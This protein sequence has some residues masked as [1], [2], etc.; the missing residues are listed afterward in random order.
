V[1]SESCPSDDVLA[2]FVLG[3]LPEEVLDSI[4][5]HQERCARCEFRACQLDEQIDPVIETIRRTISR[6]RDSDQGFVGDDPA[7]EPIVRTDRVGPEGRCISFGGPD[8]ASAPL[9]GEL[10][11]RERGLVAHERTN[12]P[13]PILPDYEIGESLL[14]RGSMG[15]VYKARHRKLN[16]VVALKM[17]A[18]SSSRAS[19]LFQIEAKAVA[20][21]QHPNIVQIFDIGNSDGQPFLALE[22]VEGGSLDQ[23]IAGHP[24]PPKFA[25][26]MVRTLARAA[27]YAH[28]QGIVHCDL[29]PSNILVTPDGIPKIADFGVA[30]W[31]ESENQW[32]HDG[33]IVGTPC[34]MAPEQASGQVKSVG[35][36]T[37]VYSL[38]VILYEMLTGRPPH[39]ASTS[40]EILTLV[41]EQE[42]VS[43]RQIQPRLPRDLETI[44]LKSLRKEPAKRYTDARSLAEDLDRFLTG[45]PI[46]ARRISRVERSYLWARRHRRSLSLVT[47]ITAFWLVILG[48]ALFRHSTLVPWY[49]A[50]PQFESRAAP[51]LRPVTPNKTIVQADGS[52]RLGAASAAIHG[53]SL[54]FEAPFGNLGYWH[55][56]NDRAVWTFQVYRPATFTL[57]VD[58]ACIDADAGNRYEVAIG[59]TLFRGVVTGTGSYLDYRVIAIGKLELAAGTHRLEVRPGGP[60]K[61]ALFDLRAVTLVPR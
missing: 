41:C 45:E 47:I 28:R 19:E 43:P 60:I 33:D 56:K 4:R 8:Q 11:S 29:K 39:H 21:L 17:I 26:E 12:I 31:L 32:G 15:V 42:P 14:G 52:I 16:R 23:R 6:Q 54:V 38:G 9:A 18:G 30:R 61:R 53:D 49:Y 10:P 35:P 27:D 7:D 36:A 58:Y 3:D 50:K 20:H 40:L 51:E 59:D 37:D 46:L 57:S 55:S 22:F 24:Q 13:Q 25:A 34:Y 2:A 5:E 44:V 48:L 1:C